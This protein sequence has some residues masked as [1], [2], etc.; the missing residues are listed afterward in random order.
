VTKA[1][2]DTYLK[3]ILLGVDP[4]DTEYLWQ[5]MYRRTTAFGRK[6]IAMTAISAVDVALRDL[7]G[8]SLNSLC[9]G[10]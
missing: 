9:I 4:W 7:L 5:Q 2:I 6:R 1:C 8:K 3:P 10:S